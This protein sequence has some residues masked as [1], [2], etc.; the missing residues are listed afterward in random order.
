MPN[1]TG[2]VFLYP[3]ITRAEQNLLLLQSILPADE[4]LYIWCYSRD[5]AYIASS[6]PRSVRDMLDQAFRALGG[7]KM[8]LEYI[9]KKDCN[10]PKIIGSSI[11]MQWAFSLETER[12]DDLLFI[13][14]PV[15]YLRP[16]K[17]QLRRALYA[18][19]H[20]FDHTDWIP[21]LSKCL[22]ELPVMSFSVFTRYILMVHNTLTS[23]QLGLEIFSQ[24][25]QEPFPH[26]AAG[27][28]NRLHVYQAE[29]ALLE[30]VRT[31]NINYQSALKTSMESSP[32]VPVQG[33]DP[34]RQ[35]KTS[36]IVFTTLVSR[37]AMEGGLSPEIAYP[38]GDSYIQA[39]ENCR[40][41]GELSALSHTMYHDYIYRVHHIRSN[42]NYSHAIQKCCD[43][44][45]LSLERK[46]RAADLAGL[47]GYTEY[48]LTEKFKNETGQS[49]TQYIRNARINRA[50]VL[51][52]STTLSV[53]EI[54]E[55]LAFNTP[56]YFIQ[57]FRNV[58][59]C[60]PAQ[61]RKRVV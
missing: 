43:Y 54:A 23:Q 25:R 45:E 39:A 8:T 41:S 19:L 5:G 36:L 60:T 9:Q 34:L 49:I 18:E 3:G 47:V 6:C 59:G 22:P 57:C 21:A 17:S 35:M 51:L 61:Y 24:A 11:G 13:I 7:M 55:Q 38:L 46:I 56:N 53:A 50:K 31:G 2:G 42:P 28:R 40:D 15:F 4:K 30:M 32:G 14:G 1:T 16:D 12:N 27:E 26:P 48:Y 29:Q 20:D 33:Q 44:I 58:T 10:H 52:N 37:A